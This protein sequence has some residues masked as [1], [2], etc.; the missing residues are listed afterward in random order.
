[1]TEQ[2][3]GKCPFGFS[4]DGSATDTSEPSYTHTAIAPALSRDKLPTLVS[5]PIAEGADG[6]P[7]GRCLC[8]GA[9][10]KITKPVKRVFANH[11]PAS[12]RWTG[13]ISLTVM[14]RATSLE[15]H[16]WGRL[17]QHAASDDALHCFCRTC[18]TSMFIRH[19]KP[20]AM[21]GM[22]SLSAGTL[23]TLDGFELAAETWIDEKPSLY[24]FEGERR[25]LTGAEI[26]ATYGGR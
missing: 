26:A 6:L 19:V 14:V 3:A 2:M 12:R 22:L 4:N 1:M 8:G 15:F 25:R 11:D 13:G 7:T 5:E 21:D 23:D 18:G 10:Y 9:S 16:G 17:V 20:E 24:N